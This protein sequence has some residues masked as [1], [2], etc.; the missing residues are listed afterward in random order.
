MPKAKQQSMLSRL[1]NDN[2]FEKRGVT[3]KKHDVFNRKVKGEGRNVAKA[4]SEAIERRNRTLL[5]SFFLR[6][7]PIVLSNAFVSLKARHLCNAVL[8]SKSNVCT[9]SPEAYTS[10]VD[11]KSNKKANAFEDKRFG[12][13]DAALPLEEKMWGRL[14]KERSRASRNARSS[15][16]NL[17]DDPVDDDGQA[18]RGNAG[19]DGPV[20]NDAD[21][22][23]D[24]NLNAE[25]VDRLH[26]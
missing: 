3:K 13:S 6:L 9:I 23:D 10:T 14:Q 21:G 20:G 18:L 24:N 5:V 4:R 7:S 1:A 15:A 19:Y 17:D 25:M 26:F 22:D 12:E 11:W 16:F 2:P 8:A